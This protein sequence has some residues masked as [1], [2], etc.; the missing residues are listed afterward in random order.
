[1]YHCGVRVK[2]SESYSKY[3]AQKR[4]IYLKELIL[5]SKSE[6]NLAVECL[7]LALIRGLRDDVSYLK[8]VQAAKMVTNEKLVAFSKGILEPPAYLCHTA[9]DWVIGKGFTPQ[10]DAEKK[11][12]VGMLLTRRHI[13]SPDDIAQ[14][15]PLHW[16]NSL[17]TSLLGLAKAEGIINETQLPVL[18]KEKGQSSC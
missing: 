9:L 18:Q 3:V 17:T 2:I 8:S 10:T 11:L 15:F 7:H 13:L 1:M 14:H 12:L 5:Y 16:S 4:H 6:G